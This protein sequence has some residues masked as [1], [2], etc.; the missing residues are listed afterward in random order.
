MQHLAA[1]G[2]PTD[3]WRNIIVVIPEHMFSC[4]YSA[5]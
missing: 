5:P 2:I 3:A 4:M 1:S